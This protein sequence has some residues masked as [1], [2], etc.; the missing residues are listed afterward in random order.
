MQRSLTLQPV[1]GFFST[2]YSNINNED[3]LLL[4]FLKEVGV[5]DHFDRHGLPFYNKYY[6]CFDPKERLLT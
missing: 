3:A 6:L 4:D 5:V 1:P 2:I